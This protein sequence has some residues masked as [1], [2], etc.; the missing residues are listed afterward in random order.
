MVAASTWES[1]HSWKPTRGTGLNGPAA[2]TFIEYME[3]ASDRRRD[4]R[5]HVS[6]PAQIRRVGGAERIEIVNASYRGLFIRTIGGAPPLNQLLKVRI[7]LPTRSIEVNCIPVRVVIDGNGR[8]GIG[9]RFF[10]LNGE[11]KQFWESYIGSLLA[12]RRAAA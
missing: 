10:A 3:Q 2:A 1:V 7:D 11:D 4:I 5:A 8:A 6:P 12:P 9:V